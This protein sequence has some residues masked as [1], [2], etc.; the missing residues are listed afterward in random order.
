MN[1]RVEIST[2][3]N[4]QLDALDAWWRENR[5]AAENRVME[6]MRRLEVL[7]ATTPD[8]GTP[9]RKRGHK[10]IRWLRLHTTPYKLYYR[11]APGT[12]LVTVVAIWSSTRKA[13]PPMPR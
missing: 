4:K 13:V 8:I 12:E 9:Y 11:H 7:L 1:I 2:D 5:P 6:E 3:A 10:N